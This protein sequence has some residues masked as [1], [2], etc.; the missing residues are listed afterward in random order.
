MAGYCTLVLYFHSPAAYEN[1]AAHSCNI[2]PYC[3]LTHQIIY[4]WQSQVEIKHNILLRILTALPR[5]KRCSAV[6]PLRADT[7]AQCELIRHIDAPPLRVGALCYS[8]SNMVTRS[9]YATE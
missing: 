3:L 6:L 4:M 8:A 9:K 2:Q 7:R 5:S 1:T